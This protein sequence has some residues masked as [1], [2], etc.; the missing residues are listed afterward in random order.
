MLDDE[1]DKQDSNFKRILNLLK[2]GN[3]NFA[4]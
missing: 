1:Q 2:K 3:A 4:A